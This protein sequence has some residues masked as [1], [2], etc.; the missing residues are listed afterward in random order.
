MFW[1]LI[2]IHVFQYESLYVQGRIEG[3]FQHVL[4]ECH[5][6][7][8]IMTNVTS[9]PDYCI[10]HTI[11]QYESLFTQGVFDAVQDVL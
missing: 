4:Y 1:K 7:T 9:E 11:Y 3:Q 5:F 8:V 10:I 2:T 6:A